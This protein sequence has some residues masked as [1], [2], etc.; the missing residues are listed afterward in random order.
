MQNII[1]AEREGVVKRST[2]RPATASPPTT[3]WWSSP[4]DGRRTRPARNAPRGLAGDGR[5]TLKGGDF[6]AGWAPHRRRPD[7]PAALHRGRRPA[8]APALPRP[9]RM[10]RTGRGT[11]APRPPI[12][13]R[14]RA[15]REI[16]GDLEG[17]AASVL[18]RARPDRPPRRRGRL[19]RRPGPGAGG[20]GPGAAPVGPGRR[21]PGAPGG[22][23]AGR[24]RQ[25]LAGAPSC[26]STSIR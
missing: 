4:E 12:P 8:L 9:P 14:A 16:L 21:L 1:R 3:C 24:R 26:T 23:L 11:S 6:D 13:T 17:G 5:Q 2:P 7:D 15:N 25:V 18:V 10:T 19:G 22:R 20:R